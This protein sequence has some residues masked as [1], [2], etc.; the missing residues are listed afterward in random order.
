MN[1]PTARLI[2]RYVT[3]INPGVTTTGDIKRFKRKWNRMSHRARAR[4]RRS[5]QRILA[6]LGEAS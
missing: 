5:M 4:K 3:R 1:A 2:R 6:T